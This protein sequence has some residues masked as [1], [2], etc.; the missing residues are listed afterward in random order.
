MATLAMLGASVGAGAATTRSTCAPDGARTIRQTP[1]IRVYVLRARVVTGVKQVE[2]A[3]WRPTGRALLLGPVGDGPANGYQVAH[4]QFASA[5]STGTRSSVLAWMT[6][7][8]GATFSFST[9]QSA[10]VRTGRR[11]RESSPP[12]SGA[13]GPSYIV[14]PTGS[15]AWVGSGG[16]INQDTGFATGPTG[17]W[18]VDAAG[19]RLLAS[20]SAVDLRWSAGILTWR[21]NGEPGSAS[22]T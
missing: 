11:I 17:V 22:L 12:N 9:L 16:P 20:G 18:A 13:A 19:E 5:K 8:T 2:Y 3:C 6:V 7:D 21:L 15:L 14:T 4:L 10:D 1:S